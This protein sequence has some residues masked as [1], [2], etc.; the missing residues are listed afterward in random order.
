[1]GTANYPQS[2]SLKKA[3]DHIVYLLVSPE[4]KIEK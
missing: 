1:M 3:N 4:G 2:A